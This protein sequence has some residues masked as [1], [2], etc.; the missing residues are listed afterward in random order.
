MWASVILRE[1]E[2]QFG[3]VGASGVMAVQCRIII[4]NHGSCVGDVIDMWRCAGVHGRRS[5]VCQEIGEKCSILSQYSTVQ[6]NH[7]QCKGS[8][9]TII[10][11]L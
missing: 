11:A 4:R 7:P 10:D 3:S 2:S 9:N 6:L 8:V 5:E 1:P